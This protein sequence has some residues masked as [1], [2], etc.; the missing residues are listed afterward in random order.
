MK[1]KNLGELMN[2]ESY[3]RINDLEDHGYFWEGKGGNI[4]AKFIDRQI[5]CINPSIMFT[6]QRT[7]EC[8]EVWV[9]SE[10]ENACNVN[11]VK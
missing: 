7:H 5:F 10:S 1:L 2:P 6:G 8:L 11:E 3:I 9:E 4:P